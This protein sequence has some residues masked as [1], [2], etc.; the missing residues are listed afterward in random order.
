MLSLLRSEKKL[1]D[2]VSEKDQTV[3][4]E[5]FVE[6]AA[7]KQDEREEAQS[8]ERT[9]CQP[10]IQEAPQLVN[11]WKRESLKKHRQQ[12]QKNRVWVQE[13]EDAVQHLRGDLRSPSFSQ[14]L[15]TPVEPWP[16]ASP[17]AALDAT[18]GA[19][20]NK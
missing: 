3:E 20:P 6:P 9:A 7:Y 14:L 19:W 15:T 5:Q 1:E 2:L 18:S 11:P 12:E 8:V 13:K 10:D 17:E 4:Q 16:P